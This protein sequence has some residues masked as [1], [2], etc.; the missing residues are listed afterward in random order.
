[1]SFKDIEI[2]INQMDNLNDLPPAPTNITQQEGV[3]ANQYFGPPTD[4]ELS[5]SGSRFA[6]IKWKTLGMSALAFAVLANPWIDG[7]LSKI[8]Y[9]GSSPSTIFAMKVLIF[10]IAMVVIQ[11]FE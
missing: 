1:M 9:C 5:N 2:K 10:L 3:I 8:P 7:F 4:I 6:K 11:M